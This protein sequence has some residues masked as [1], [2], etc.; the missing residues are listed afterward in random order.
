MIIRVNLKRQK[1]NTF[2]WLYWVLRPQW[3]WHVCLTPTSLWQN[4]Q[5]LFFF[6]LSCTSISCR[7]ITITN[8]RTDGSRRS[9][10]GKSS[11]SAPKRAWTLNNRRCHQIFLI[12]NVN[13]RDINI[14]L[15]NLDSWHA[16]RCHQKGR[17]AQ[18][19][20][21][22]LVCQFAMAGEKCSMELFA[23][24]IYSTAIKSISMKNHIWIIFPRLTTDAVATKLFVVRSWWGTDGYN[25]VK[26]DAEWHT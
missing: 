2:P 5:P 25:S 10:K 24:Q 15:L 19:C 17:V 22:A 26:K 8:D 13:S 18:K 7:A 20:S 12:E 9:K 14:S 4:L 11:K 3:D 6:L 1:A 21:S 16:R 23:A